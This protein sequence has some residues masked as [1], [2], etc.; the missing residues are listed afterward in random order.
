[1]LSML[2]PTNPLNQS[3]DYEHFGECEESNE[4]DEAYSE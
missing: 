2:M 3:D 1:M 4:A